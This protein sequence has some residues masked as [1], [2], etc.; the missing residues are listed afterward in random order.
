MS[1]NIPLAR[2][3]DDHADAELSAT[4]N[5]LAIVE[6]VDHRKPG[7]HRIDRSLCVA[8][9]D[10]LQLVVRQSDRADESRVDELCHGSPR[11][12][13]RDARVVGPMEEVD[14]ELLTSEPAKAVAARRMNLV[15]AEP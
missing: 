12:L 7:L 9:L 10:V 1:L 13:E 8:A 11:F 6:V 15:M 2:F 14:V 3:V 4:G 5:Q